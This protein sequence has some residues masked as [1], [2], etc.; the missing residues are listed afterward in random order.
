MRAPGSNAMDA[1]LKT[2]N[3]ITG[4]ARRVLKRLRDARDLNLSAAKIRAELD[5]FDKL[6]LT[7]DRNHDD[8]LD[9]IDLDPDKH[10]SEIAAA[11]EREKKWMEE[12]EE[13]YKPQVKAAVEYMSSLPVIVDNVASSQPAETPALSQ[14]L[15]SSEGAASIDSLEEA[16]KQLSVAT[17]SQRPPAVQVP[18]FDGNPKNFNFFFTLFEELIAKVCPTQRVKLAQLLC[19]VKGPALDAIYH[20]LSY[21][22]STCY[23]K[24]VEILKLRFG[25]AT[26]IARIAL[27]DLYNGDLCVSSSDLNTFVEELKNTKRQVAATVYANALSSHEAIDKLLIRLPS[28]VQNKWTKVARRYIKLHGNYPD[29]DNFQQFIVELAEELGD[30]MYGIDSSLRRAELSR[31]RA[32]GKKSVTSSSVQLS[33]TPA[34]QF[35][36][37]LQK[38]FTAVEKT[39]TAGSSIMLPSDFQTRVTYGREPSFSCPPGD[40]NVFLDPAAV[41]M[42]SKQY[43]GPQKEKGKGPKGNCPFCGKPVHSL[44]DCSVFM[45]ASQAERWNMDK[46]KLAYNCWKCM[47]V[48]CKKSCPFTPYKCCALPYHIVLHPP[49]CIQIVNNMLTKSVASSSFI[50]PI[51]EV[52]IG[53]EKV[54]VYLDNCS[55][56]SFI[57]DRFLKSGGLRVKDEVMCSSGS[58]HGSQILSTKIVDFTIRPPGS[59]VKYDITNAFVVSRLPAG[60]R[61]VACD[62][63][64][65][66]HLQGLPL[67]AHS[68]D[69]EVSALI[70]QDHSHLLTPLE[71]RKHPDFPSVQVR[72]KPYAVKTLLGWAISGRGCVREPGKREVALLITHHDVEGNLQ[73]LWDVER[74][75]DEKTEKSIIDRDVESKWKSTYEIDDENHYVV[76]IPLKNPDTTFPDN[77]EYALDRLRKIIRNLKSKNAFESYKSQILSMI[78]DGYAEK[79]PEDEIFRA[80]GFIFYLPH[81]PVYH[82]DKPGKVRVVN[83]CKAEFEDVSVNNVCLSGPD[84]LNKLIHVLLRFRMHQYAWAADV[85]AMYFQVRIPKEQRDM[86]RFLWINDDGVVEEYR[87]VG[88]VMGGVWSSASSTFAIRQAV[89]DRKSHPKVVNVINNSLY[90]DDALHS[91]EKE[92]DAEL[93]AHGCYTDLKKNH[94]NFC[95]YVSTHPS[96]LRR[97]PRELHG[98]AMRVIEGDPECKA[99]GLR[100]NIEKDFFYYVRDKL[101]DFTDM[102]MR[103][104]L[105]QVATLYDP[106]GLIQPIILIGKLIFQRVTRLKIGWDDLLPPSELNAWR[107]WF[108]GLENI[109]QLHFPRCLVGTLYV[110]ARKELHT[111]CDASELA[112]GT[113][114]Y[115]RAVPDHGDIKVILIMGKGRV[116]PN[117]ALT[118]PRLELQAALTGIKQEKVIRRET[119]IETVQRYF[120]TDSIIVLHY[121]KNPALRLKTFVARRVDEI[122]DHSAPEQWHHVRTDQNPADIVS[123]GVP[124]AADLPDLWISGPLFLRKPMEQWPEEVTTLPVPKHPLEVKSMLS[125]ILPNTPAPVRVT[126]TTSSC[127]GGEH[128]CLLAVAAGGEPALVDSYC[129]TCRKEGVA[130]LD[131]EL[132]LPAPEVIETST[133]AVVTR[134]ALR[135]NDH[136][137]IQ[138]VPE[139]VGVQP[140]TREKTKRKLAP[141]RPRDDVSTPGAAE[142]EVET[143]DKTQELPA[144]GRRKRDVSTPG[145]AK[146]KVEPH[147]TIPWPK[148]PHLIYTDPIGSM[149]RYFGDADRLIK[150]YA[151]WRRPCKLL[152]GE[153]VKGDL[154][155]EELQEAEKLL[156]R[157]VQY[158]VYSAEIKALK[159]RRRLPATSDILPLNPALEDGML[160]VQGRLRHL[161]SVDVNSR[162]YIL[163]KNHRLSTLLCRRVHCSSHVGSE[164]ALSM[165]R[166][167]YWIIAARSVLRSVRRTCVVC[168]R[169]HKAPEQ[170]KMADLPPERLV[171]GPVCFMNVGVDLF[172]PFLVTVGRASVKRYGVVFTCLSARA[173]HLEVVYTMNTDSFIMALMRFVC[174]RGI[175]IKMLSDRGTNIVGA[176]T[177]L[178]AAWNDVNTEA[179]TLAA[180][181]KGIEWKFNPPKASNMGG[182]WERQIRTVRSCLNPIFRTQTSLDDETLYTAFVEVE[183]LINSRPLTKVSADPEDGVLT[184]NHLLILQDNTKYAAQE[185]D[186]GAV[187]RRKWK[188][189]MQIRD[190]FWKTWTSRYLQDLQVR[191][192]WHQDSPE[193]SPDDIVLQLDENLPR[194]AWP[195][196]VVTSVKKSHDGKVRS[197]DIKTSKSNY[198][199]PVNKLVK[200]ELD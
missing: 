30:H 45:G 28:D 81:F 1:A 101:T 172:G 79:V 63:A 91:E 153:M 159:E 20:A 133:M 65:S 40:G 8:F 80:D 4:K 60:R 130:P 141:G 74:E 134:G 185:L 199:R 108:K 115:L 168:Q 114:T 176:E 124:V 94:F 68:E 10:P 52:Y 15:A 90:V 106:I 82:P 125:T 171:A 192:K 87:M 107:R 135:K 113:A 136:D 119:N 95:K 77:R 21:P 59:H 72:S 71:V 13:E 186:L 150:T 35:S 58:I 64:D 128:V 42:V 6:N 70:G 24:A 160:V 139:V 182:V 126:M 34:G 131:G 5:S 195:L 191:Q 14:T 69:V 56:H 96:T 86:L 76:S 36:V 48:G 26:E 189:V 38:T 112:Y 9:R 148:K 66:P 156:V 179:L 194:G 2:R 181:N 105:S 149:I 174:R 140:S 46:L 127:Y 73:R 121:L 12:W 110:G 187:Y 57:T 75:L 103:K 104:L 41:T 62:V 161:S 188:R 43:P 100:W 145:V 102:T 88:H 173:I 99:L 164:W 22:P 7:V 190:Q 184:P 39:D 177:E 165:L 92:E 143:L 155:V 138:A 25:N 167:K 32:N 118:I 137:V 78:A 11:Q 50:L 54:F 16:L 85:A 116:S 196:A 109:H 170:Q 93:T 37:P 198:T 166:S 3:Q 146:T 97:I 163:P 154:T 178:N 55:T 47:K 67:A 98:D 183:N 89:V 17:N 53:N 51:V 123:R 19:Y 162:P 27:E 132:T 84:L 117:K 157:H 29:L 152:R 122:L 169:F 33:G 111:F 23:D 197:V 49:H 83:D 18:V 144:S 180:R 193:L 158:E 120:W 129:F 142:T 44:L 31:Q 175:P 147:L 151:W 61:A 200:L